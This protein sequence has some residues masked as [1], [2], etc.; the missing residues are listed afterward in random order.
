MQTM[1]Y[2]QR[3]HNDGKLLKTA[4]PVL[5]LLGT[6]DIGLIS[7][8]L[9]YYLIRNYGDFGSV[10]GEAM[11]WSVDLHIFV[12]TVTQAAVRSLFA[13]RIRKLTRN[14]VPVLAISVLCV[15][16][17]SSSIA[18]TIKGSRDTSVKLGT[19]DRLFNAL[20][21]VN[22]ASSFA[23]DALVAV[24]LCYLLQT[25]RTGFG[26]MEQI[27]K[28][29]SAY[30]ITTGLLT[31]MVQSVALILFLVSSKSFVYLAVLTQVSKLYVNAYL[32]MLNN[33]E[34]IR[35]LGSVRIS[36]T[37]SRLQPGIGSRIAERELERERQTSTSKTGAILDDPETSYAV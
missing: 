18:L 15:V 2:Y 37:P 17:L 5:W 3:E 20:V 7:H 21:C 26:R 1:A 13:I 10:T 27:I 22:F 8:F 28:T 29:L 25:S 4:V 12:I 19:P 31:T 6:V 30:I 11:V 23:G 36:M 24:C 16:D 34:R 32:A 14:W 9:Y 35:E 33:R